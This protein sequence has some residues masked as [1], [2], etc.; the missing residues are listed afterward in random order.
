[1]NR[2]LTWRKSLRHFVFV[3]H[4]L[5]VACGLCHAQGTQQRLTNF[6][7]AITLLGSHEA[8]ISTRIGVAGGGSLPALRLTLLRYRRQEIRDIKV[9]DLSGRP[10]H[11]TTEVEP[12][13]VIVRVSQP[14]EDTRSEAAF[15][16]EYMVAGLPADV[17]R[18]PTPVPEAR[19]FF[20]E[21]PVQITITAS[22]SQDLLHD[23]F[24]ALTTDGQK[25]VSAK[26]ADV[27]S[28]V[29][30][31]RIST[32]GSLLDGLYTTSR[33][34][35]IAMVALVVVGSCL[36]FSRSRRK[37]RRRVAAT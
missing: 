31:H 12:A 2:P 6:Q 24:P 15:V 1:M 33:L 23:G 37:V 20:G 13:A 28:V 35:E 10:L 34:S 9:M 29:M 3:T 5:A 30:I 32:S 4:L 21:L 36:W 14:G 7:S 11:S 8:A 16:I 19:S 17:I 22:N 18:I 27:P 25:Y 26:L